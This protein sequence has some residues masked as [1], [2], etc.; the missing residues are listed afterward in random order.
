MHPYFSF[1]PAKQIPTVESLHSLCTAISRLLI[2]KLLQSGWLW[3]IDTDR[4]RPS[5]VPLGEGWEADDVQYRSMTGMVQQFMEPSPKWRCHLLVL[6]Y[7][8]R[9][10]V[11]VAPIATGKSQQRRKNQDS[12]ITISPL[13]DLERQVAFVAV[14][15][16]SLEAVSHK[17]QWANAVSQPPW[18]TQTSFHN[19]ENWQAY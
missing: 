16:W 5:W 10:S 15:T 4:A 18:W 11:V 3:L 6:G 7:Q 9:S 2:V 8:P 19:Q 17:Q 13:I 14:V 12:H 1:L